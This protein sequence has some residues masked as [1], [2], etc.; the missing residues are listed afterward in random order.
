[1][2]NLQPEKTRQEQFLIL[3]RRYGSSHALAST[4]TFF[5][6]VRNGH[7]W[8][9]VVW[10]VNK[11]NITISNYDSMHFENMTDIKIVEEYVLHTA[12]RL[13]QE[14]TIHI[15]ILPHAPSNMIKQADGCSCGVYCAMIADCLTSN[16][17]IQ[18]LTPTSIIGDRQRM[19]QNILGQTAPRLISAHA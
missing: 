4:W 6:V 18:L 1:M 9:I 5:H 17:N 14:H 13:G 2:Q 19:V 10:N 7:Y 16:I 3:D 11:G 15:T 8:L 12:Q